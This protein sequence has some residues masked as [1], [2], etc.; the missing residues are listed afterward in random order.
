MIE[1]NTKKKTERIIFGIGKRKKRWSA[2]YN[3]FSDRET[4]SIWYEP[5]K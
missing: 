3:S 2:Y 5:K 1:V 4:Y